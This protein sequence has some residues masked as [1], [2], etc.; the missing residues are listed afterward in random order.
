VISPRFSL[1]STLF[2]L[3]PVPQHQHLPVPTLT[4]LLLH[5]F[6]GNHIAH[7]LVLAQPLL[8]ISRMRI[9]CQDSRSLRCISCA[10]WRAQM[11]H[12]S[13]LAVDSPGL[14]WMS[15]K[16]SAQSPKVIV[17]LVVPTLTHHLPSASSFTH[18]PPPSPPTISSV[19]SGGGSFAPPSSPSPWLRSPKLASRPSL[20]AR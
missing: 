4:D 9:G 12:F 14:V 6:L 19:S 13:F 10:T 16:M 7:V 3:Q 11:V 17:C 2:L 18:S 5:R 15:I 20:C 1:L 8:H